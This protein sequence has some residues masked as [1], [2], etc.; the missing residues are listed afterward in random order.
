MRT[1][2]TVSTITKQCAFFCLPCHAKNTG[3]RQAEEVK[4]E[5]KKMS[6]EDKEVD[7]ESGDEV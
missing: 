5:N 3:A 2:P 6:D 4:Q 1:C 7:V